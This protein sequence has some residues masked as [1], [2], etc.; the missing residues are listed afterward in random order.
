MEMDETENG[1]RKVKR[2]AEMEILKF[3]NDHQ[4]SSQDSAY[5]VNVS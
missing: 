3:G 5:K 1:N 4:S 2:K